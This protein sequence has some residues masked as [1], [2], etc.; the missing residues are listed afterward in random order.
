MVRK[1]QL[2]DRSVH[3]TK[4]DIESIA[5]YVY[6]GQFEE[7]E[8]TL[9]NMHYDLRSIR[10]RLGPAARIL[11]WAFMQLASVSDQIG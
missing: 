3:F 10:T 7:L 6:Y 8:A 4:P 5:V 1:S 9:V 11:L 2:Q